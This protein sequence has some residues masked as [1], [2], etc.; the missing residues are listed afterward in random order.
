MADA[1]GHAAV[2]WNAMGNEWEALKWAY[3]AIEGQLINNGE[4]DRELE[5][6]R[7]LVSDPRGHWT[8]RRRVGGV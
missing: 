5:D 3:R 1:Y 8:W 4:G 2:A 7:E 6:L